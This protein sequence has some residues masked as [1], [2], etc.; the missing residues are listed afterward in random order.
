MKSISLALGIVLVLSGTANSWASA[1]VVSTAAGVTGKVGVKATT[2][3]VGSVL[4]G[5]M[6]VTVS[7]SRVAAERDIDTVLRY[8]DGCEVRLK[9]GAVYTISDEPPCKVGVVSVT[10]ASGFSI[11]PAAISGLAVAGAVIG[12]VVVA[13]SGKKASS[14]IYIS[15]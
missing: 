12:G 13:T 2:Y 3:T 5:G 15:P 4:D 6:R 14:P 10:E 1:T 11:G 9:Q 7:N 8:E